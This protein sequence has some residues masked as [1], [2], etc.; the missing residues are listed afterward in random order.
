MKL[1]AVFAPAALAA[2][3]SIDRQTLA[4]CGWQEFVFIGT[5]S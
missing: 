5:R 3:I 1:K 2:A 4:E